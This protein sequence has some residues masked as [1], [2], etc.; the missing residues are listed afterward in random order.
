MRIFRSYQQVFIYN[1]ITTAKNIILEIT[2]CNRAI[3]AHTPQHFLENHMNI[4]LNKFN[5]LVFHIFFNTLIS[6]VK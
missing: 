3:V 6:H 5:F 4:K 2:D 1:K